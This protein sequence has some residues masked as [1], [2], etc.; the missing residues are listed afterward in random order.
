MSKYSHLFFDLDNTLFDFQA[1]SEIAL[2]VFADALKA[3]YNDSFKAVYKK[4]NHSA[5]MKFERNLIDGISLRK[6]RFEDTANELGYK[7]DGLI[8]NRM[9]LKQLVE[10]PR[11]ID[12]AKETLEKYSRTHTLVAVTNG[13]KEVQRP[14]LRKVD[15]EKFFSHIVVSDEIGIAKP[16]HAYFQYA[17]EKA[18]KPSKDKVLMIGD[19]PFS[20][21]K[22][23]SEFG[24]DTCY[25]DVFNRGKEVEL[26]TYSITN[27][28]ALDEIIQ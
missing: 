19:N 17:W 1:S 24:F 7:I 14:R 23:A 4:Y 27:L 22:G 25:I 26:A 11:F 18:G 21:I 5:W 28:K 6:S 8:I 2:K 12:G 13:L 3:D 15:F 16:D 20:D 9:Y 10:N